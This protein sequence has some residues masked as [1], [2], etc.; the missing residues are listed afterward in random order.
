MGNNDEHTGPWGIGDYSRDLSGSTGGRDH[1][2]TGEGEKSLVSEWLNSSKPHHMDEV[3]DMYIFHIYM[4]VSSF[5]YKY[6]WCLYEH[7]YIGKCSPIDGVY[8]Q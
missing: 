5:S 2:S 8:A 3:S 4:F 6:I 7:K 1:G